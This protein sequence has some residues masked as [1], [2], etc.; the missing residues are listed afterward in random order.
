MIVPA[1][2]LGLLTQRSEFRRLRQ[3]CSIEPLISNEVRRPVPAAA[4]MPI[5]E[6]AARLSLP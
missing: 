2:M 1:G 3:I 5:F 4:R 6:F